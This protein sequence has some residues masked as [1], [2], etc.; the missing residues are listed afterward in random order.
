MLLRHDWSQLIITFIK[1]FF[2]ETAFGINL[3]IQNQANH[4]LFEGVSQY[5]TNLGNQIYKPWTNIEVIY[6]LLPIS[7]KQEELKKKIYNFIDDVS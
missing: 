5:L 3:N 7:V 4:T 6:N 1:T 2:S